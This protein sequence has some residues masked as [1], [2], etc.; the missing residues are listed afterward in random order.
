M[1]TSEIEQK[2][3]AVLSDS[4]GREVGPPWTA[5]QKSAWKDLTGAPFE[6]RPR[7]PAADR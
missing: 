7:R 2:M 4:L 3:W 5:D 6:L 1:D